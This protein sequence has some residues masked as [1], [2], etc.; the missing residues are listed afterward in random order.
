MQVERKHKTLSEL[1]RYIRSLIEGNLGGKRFWLKAEI[2]QVKE[3]LSGHAYIDLV[4]HKEA[5]PIARSRAMIWSNTLQKV[6]ADLGNDYPNIMKQ[7][8]EIM[9]L[10]EAGFS[11]LY[12]F[13]ITIHEVDLSF[14][15]GEMERRKQAT[16]ARLEKE[17][18]FD[19]NSRL[20]LPVVVQKI[21]II[22]AK[23]SDG[24]KDLTEQLSRNQYGYIFHTELFPAMVQG[25][26][27]AQQIIGQ[28]EKIGSDF[29]AI[30]I[31]RG[32]GSKLDLDAF[33][34]YELCATI[35]QCKIPVLTGIG[36]ENDIS[37]ADMVAHTR[38]KT[39]SAVGAFLVEKANQFEIG[40][41]RDYDRIRSN[42]QNRV[43]VLTEQLQHR[44]T[45]L[46]NRAISY[47]Q[48]RRGEL[49]KNAGKVVRFAKGIAAEK[50]RKLSHLEDRMSY[51]PLQI[52][53]D[54]SA[55]LKHFAELLKDR[56]RNIIRGAE[57]QL[58]RQTENMAR[59]SRQVLKN[60]KILLENRHQHLVNLHPN[61][62]LK[63]GFSITRKSDH[64]I[65]HLTK[66]KEGDLLEIEIYKKK[67]FVQYL[68]DEPKWNELK[69][70]VTKM[71]QKS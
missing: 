34:D 6:K 63:R 15:L 50:N 9:C 43:S 70:L 56:T 53:K 65:T 31:V 14:N 8:S 42:Y 67:I 46:R 40:M 57:Q 47:S 58:S 48:L 62:I 13:S 61:R 5:K 33:N 68:N 71:P 25:E 41:K 52:L 18:L 39:P 4:E 44:T 36:H 20:K 11:E 17:K 60:E 16:I 24:L 49:H 26:K 27:S 3:H 2:S 30:V 10:V 23:G 7:G 22:S 51:V 59:N 35:A 12:G 1:T 29:E 28:L 69:D 54:S 32:G 19:V 37:I 55:D 38:L 66:L 64:A 45:Q 21:A